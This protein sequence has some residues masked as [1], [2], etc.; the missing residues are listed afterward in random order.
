MVSVDIDV[1]NNEERV[2]INGICKDEKLSTITRQKVLDS[3][4][5]S[6]QISTDAMIMDLLDSTSSKMKVMTD[7][8]WDALKVLTP[9]PVAVLPQDDVE[10]VPSDEEEL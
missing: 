9:F 5:F 2:L 3:L 7:E 6:K 8:E 10:V 4:N 1:F